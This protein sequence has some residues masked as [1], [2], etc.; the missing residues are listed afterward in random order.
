[1]EINPELFRNGDIVEAQFSFIAVPLRGDRFKMIV[2]L[3]G[4]TLLDTSERVVS[5]CIHLM[6]ALFHSYMYAQ[7]AN[8]VRQSQQTPGMAVTIK[9]LKQKALYTEDEEVIETNGRMAKMRIDDD[10]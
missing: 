1:M 6:T 3:R 7:A 4:L 10:G 2:A 5:T 8:N 9:L